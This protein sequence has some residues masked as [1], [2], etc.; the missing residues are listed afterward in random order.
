MAVYWFTGW[1]RECCLPQ[2]VKRVNGVTL[3]ITSYQTLSP[4][5]RTFVFLDSRCTQPL[6]PRD[7]HALRDEFSKWR[8]GQ[9]GKL[10]KQSD[11]AMNTQ[12]TPSLERRIHG[13]KI[14]TIWYWDRYDIKST[15]RARFQLILYII[16]I[17]YIIII[18]IYY[19]IIIYI[20]YIIIIYIYMKVY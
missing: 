1:N 7:A 14:Q 5:R 11:F 9:R 8:T 10:K 3:S 19:I 18:Y 12:H 15:P 20:Y 2:R 17:Y 13:R 16:Y 4:V 6:T